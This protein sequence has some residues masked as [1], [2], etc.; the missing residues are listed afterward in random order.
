MVR[1][2]TIDGVVFE[3]IPVEDV[4]YAYERIEQ[5]LHKI[6]KKTYADWIP[7]DIYAALKIGNADLFIGYDRE[8]YAGF[9]ITSFIEDASGQPT[10]FLW[11]AYQN[12]AYGHKDRG[13][14]FLDNLA[15]EFNVSAIEFSSSRKGW[16]R[17]AKKYGYEPVTEIYRKEM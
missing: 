16:A 3:H 17:A 2:S 4:R 15:E 14:I 11:A 6:R 5:D 1:R 13:F 7:A 8:Y 9:I 10:L 12:P